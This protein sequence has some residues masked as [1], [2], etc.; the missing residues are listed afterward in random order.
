MQKAGFISI[1]GRPNSGKSTLLNSL[2][3]MQLS[4]VTPKAQTTRERVLGIFTQGDN[5]IIFIDTP[6]IHRAREGG[7]NQF[8]VEE[9]QQALEAPHLVWYLVDP[10]SS[11]FHEVQVLELLVGTPAPVV[12]LMN[13]VDLLGRRFPPERVQQFQDEMVKALEERGIQIHSVQQI[14]GLNE[15]GTREL[16]ASSMDAIPVGHWFY[17]D[18]EQASDRPTRFFVAEK[19][20]SR[21]FYLLGDEVPYSCGVEIDSF[22][23]TVQPIRIEATI[24]VERESQKGIVIG[25]GGKKIKEIGQSAREEIEE[26]LGQKIFLGLKVKVL[27][28]WT[29]NPEDLRRM[30]LKR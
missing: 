30:G 18:P 26:F 2:L 3:G 17:P 9:A 27:K 11:L 25:Q 19:I 20:R 6:G 8:M 5:Q 29:S 4:I 24:Y 7:L 12:L 14:S 28:D 16:L 13:K 1:I 10:N 15:T 22:Q 23:E 21:L